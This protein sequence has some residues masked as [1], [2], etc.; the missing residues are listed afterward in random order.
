MVSLLLLISCVRHDFLAILVALLL[1]TLPRRRG[2]DVTSA[3]NFLPPLPSCKREEVSGM[4]RLIAQAEG[5]L[6]L[7]CCLHHSQGNC[8]Y[9]IYIYILFIFMIMQIELGVGLL[10]KTLSIKGVLEALYILYSYIC[11]SSKLYYCQT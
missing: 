7:S 11:I 2:D 1:L 5:I 10:Y 9:P 6:T 4:L 8:V 3:C